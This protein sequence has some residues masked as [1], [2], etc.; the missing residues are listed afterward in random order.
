M[1][2]LMS[3]IVRSLARLLAGRRADS[4]AQELE[5]LVLRHQLRVLR[6]K[7]GHPNLRRLDRVL[8]ASASRVLPRDRWSSFMLTPQTLVRWHRELV[9]RK[10]LRTGRKAGTAPD[11]PQGPRPDPSSGPR[12]LPVGRCTHPRGA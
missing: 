2:F 1:L 8:L 6:R 10:W 11:R 9:R 7:S 3:L 5:I 12:E 4:G